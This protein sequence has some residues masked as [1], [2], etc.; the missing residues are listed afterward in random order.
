MATK[1][2][3]ENISSSQPHFSTMAKILSIMLL[4]ITMNVHKV[5]SASK[6]TI[7]NE[8]G[9][10][11]WCHCASGKDLGVHVLHDQEEWCWTFHATIWRDT[12]FYC[13]FEWINNDGQV[14]KQDFP[15]WIEGGLVY[16]SIKCGQ[17]FW[18][19]GSTG[20]SVWDKTTMSFI[21]AYDWTPSPAAV[22][23]KQLHVG[24]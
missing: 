8:A 14:F 24:N 5:H 12:E 11:V 10:D 15:V 1:P 13:W 23:S 2:S 20:F 9:S 19:A 22:N 21:H 4:L 18:K 16:K 17:C 3:R 7:R 6:V